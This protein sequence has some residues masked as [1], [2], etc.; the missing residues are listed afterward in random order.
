MYSYENG[1]GPELIRQAKRGDAKAFSSLYAGI[2][3]DLYKFALYT[4]RHPQD[5]EDAVS[6]TVITAWEK[7]GRLKKEEAF[8]SWMF[9]ILKNQCRKMLRERARKDKERKEDVFSGTT[10]SREPDYA[11]Q[12]DVREAFGALG[13][14]ERM[15]VAFSVFGGYQSDEIGSIMGTKPATVRSKKSRAMEKMRRLLAP[16]TG[17]IEE[18]T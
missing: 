1:S 15:I 12:H 5:A 18:R 13:E 6:E 2:Y 3:K 7:I 16:C 9:T 4:T 10:G 8:R 17:D 14:D 11:G